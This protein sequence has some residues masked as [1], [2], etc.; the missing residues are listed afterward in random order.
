MS[1]V[2]FDDT[3]LARVARLA[4]VR[5]PLR[6]LGRQAVEVLVARLETRGQDIAPRD[7]AN[8]VLATEL[9]LG[10]HAGGAKGLR[11]HHCPMTM[12]ARLR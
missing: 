3:V 6:E 4:T 11:D 2:G 8:I 1:V 10:C 12:V 7:A 5:Q 9:V